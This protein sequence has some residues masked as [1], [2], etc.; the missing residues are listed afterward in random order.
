VATFYADPVKVQC[1]A[2]SLQK[3]LWLRRVSTGTS[4]GWRCWRGAW[5]VAQSGLGRLRDLK[6]MVPIAALDKN[7]TDALGRA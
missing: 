3:A 5:F 6:R 2:E 1:E 4:L 7:A